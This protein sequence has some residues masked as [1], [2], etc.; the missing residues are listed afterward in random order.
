MRLPRDMSGRELIRAL[1]QAYGYRKLHQEGSH[2]ILETDAPR[3]H[4]L[5]VPAH[6]VLRLGTLSAI[7]RA[8][9]R[10]QGA[11]KDEVAR[12]LFR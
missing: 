6:K 4:R 10:A 5:S 9:A 3:R 2:V 8:V 1:Q 11:S 7:L 12:Q